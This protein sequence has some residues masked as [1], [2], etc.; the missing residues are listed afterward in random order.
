MGY[1]VL[2]IDDLRVN[3]ATVDNGG[4]EDG[5][6]SSPWSSVGT[7]L[8]TLMDSGYPPEYIYEGSYACALIPNPAGSSSYCTVYYLLSS[9]ASDDV[10]TFKYQIVYAENEPGNTVGIGAYIFG[11]PYVSEAYALFSEVFEDG[12]SPATTDWTECTLNVADTG[13]TGQTD[14]YIE[15]WSWQESEGTSSDA[16]HAILQFDNIDLYSGTP[17]IEFTNGDFET[18]NLDNWTV[19]GSATTSTDVVH[20]GTKACYIDGSGVGIM[21]KIDLT[22]ME[23]LNIYYNIPYT[24]G[25][26]RINIDTLEAS[27][28]LTCSDYYTTGGWICRRLDVSALSNVHILDITTYGASAYIDDITVQATFDNQILYGDFEDGTWFNTYTD[29]S[30]NSE[31]P[32]TSG[33]DGSRCLFLDPDWSWGGTQTA[34]AYTYSDLTY[35]DSI[36]FQY[37]I[38]VFSPGYTNIGGAWLKIQL[39]KTGS[40]T[41]TYTI[42]DADNGV[43]NDW[44]EYSLDVSD[45]TGVYK[46]TIYAESQDADYSLHPYCNAYIDGV[47]EYGTPI[48]IEQHMYV[49]NQYNTDERCD[50]MAASI[51]CDMP[52]SS[53]LDNIFTHRLTDTGKYIG[54]DEQDMDELGSIHSVFNIYNIMHMKVRRIK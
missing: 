24:E 31:Y 36:K 48:I 2:I 20:S 53:V 3:G 33:I 9:A 27:T 44:T 15:V 17:W 22:G 32:P 42:A 37:K 26:L 41:L 19:V 46:V 50:D 54:F 1:A 51:F 23:Q 49:R 34:S 12:A 38:P 13:A 47:I 28:V 14:I 16:A 25:F 45:L 52:L 35:V 43:I 40:P 8:P 7:E 10:I 29:Y 5:D 6:I 21:Q 18:G 39:T 11:D 30:G 4:F